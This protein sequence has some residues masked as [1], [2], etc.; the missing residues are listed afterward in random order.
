MLLQRRRQIR[1]RSARLAEELRRGAAGGI[2]LARTQPTLLSIYCLPVQPHQFCFG[3]AWPESGLP[4]PYRSAREWGPRHER[5]P[6]IDLLAQPASLS[7]APLAARR[8]ALQGPRS[9]A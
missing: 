5:A 1:N 6:Q 2:L 3:V 7:H 4:H 9:T 8:S